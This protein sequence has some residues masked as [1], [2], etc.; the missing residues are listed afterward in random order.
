MSSDGAL[1]L[2][3]HLLAKDSEYQKLRAE[4]SSK[5][6]NAQLSLLADQIRAGTSSPASEHRAESRF[7]GPFQTEIFSVTPPYTSGG[8][9]PPVQVRPLPGSQPQLIGIQEFADPATGLISVGVV[10]GLVTG[11]GFGGGNNKPFLIP[12]PD[13]WILGDAITS[14]ASLYQVSG[15]TERFVGN[16]IIATGEFGWQV[17]E[18]PNVPVLADSFAEAI[19][20]N[21]GSMT[22]SLKGYVGVVASIDVAASLVQGNKILA[23]NSAGEN[24]LNIAIDA[25]LT[26]TT[27]DVGNNKYLSRIWA[28]DGNIGRDLNLTVSIPYDKRADQLVVECKVILAGLRGGIDDPEGGL[29]NAAFQNVN[30]QTPQT[31]IEPFRGCPFIVRRM[32]ATT[33]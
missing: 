19:T 26:G 15:I 13:R 17:Q 8:P 11:G 32:S 30:K 18:I 1:E 24:I 31:G 23:S 12:M 2:I 22:S 28:F 14:S 21:P 29:I 3:H 4:Q 5:L 20:Y 16:E 10:G 33:V 27:P 7:P 9:N 6:M 25:E